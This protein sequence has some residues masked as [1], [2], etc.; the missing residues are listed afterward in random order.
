MSSA[1]PDGTVKSLDADERPTL[2]PLN[3]QH[4]H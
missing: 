1:G 4:N 3:E 2:C